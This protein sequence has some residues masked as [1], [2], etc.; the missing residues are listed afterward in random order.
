MVQHIVALPTL[1][2]SHEKI[3]FAKHSGISEASCSWRQDLSPSSG[4]SCNTVWGS[5]GAVLHSSWLWS[6]VCIQSWLRDLLGFWASINAR[7]N[8]LIGRVLFS[9]YHGSS[10]YHRIK[11][12]LYSGFSHPL[13]WDREYPPWCVNLNPGP[14]TWSGTHFP[15]DGSSWYLEIGSIWGNNKRRIKWVIKFSFYFRIRYN[16]RRCI[17]HSYVF[18]F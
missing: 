17:D 6:Q 14:Q 5:W 4:T 8:D 12:H 3:I 16:Y 7:C 9:H 11:A 1:T 15:L 13:S 2:S 10:F 18:F